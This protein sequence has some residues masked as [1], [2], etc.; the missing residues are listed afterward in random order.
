MERLYVPNEGYALMER[1]HTLKYLG[2][3][4]IMSM[5]SMRGC[6]CEIASALAPKVL[7]SQPVG[8][9]LC[10]WRLNLLVCLY[11]VRPSSVC[12]MLASIADT[13][14]LY[15]GS[16][17]GGAGGQLPPPPHFLKR[18]ALPPFPQNPSLLTSQFSQIY[19]YLWQI[20]DRYSKIQSK[21]A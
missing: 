14:L 20:M 1:S 2:T 13:S 9:R 7:P 19:L 4:T 16:G 15:I 21:A 10:I 18:G 8:L 12:R 6:T 17:T 3:W 11:R 5:L